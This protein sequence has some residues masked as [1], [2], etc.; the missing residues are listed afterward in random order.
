MVRVVSDFTHHHRHHH[1]YNAAILEISVFMGLLEI[2]ES[3]A[4]I[5]TISV[6]G[7]HNTGKTSLINQFIG[8]KATRTCSNLGLC[9]Q[10]LNIP[11]SNMMIQFIETRHLT[12]N[13]PDVILL[14]CTLTS[15]NSFEKIKSIFNSKFSHS[16]DEPSNV[17]VIVNK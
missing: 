8:K 7:D 3:D 10:Q 6:L 14:V 11:H 15:K 2:L 13:S 1:H 12:S 17:H 4:R 9:I 5:M 16:I